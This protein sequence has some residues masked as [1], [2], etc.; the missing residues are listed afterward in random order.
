MIGNVYPEGTRSRLQ[1]GRPEEAKVY[2]EGI[3]TR[4]QAGRPEDAKV[5]PEGTR[6]RL[7]A[8]RPTNTKVY[9]ERT[10]GTTFKVAFFRR[11]KVSS[12]FVRFCFII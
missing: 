10:T 7:Q 6:S 4:L 2:P 11:S 12:V 8:G 5:Y 9:P 1:A 3:R